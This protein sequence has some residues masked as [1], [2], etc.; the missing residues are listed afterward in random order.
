MHWT[1]LQTLKIADTN[2]RFVRKMTGQMPVLQSLKLGM[3]WTKGWCDIANQ[4][5]RF[6]AASP[7][8]SNLSLHG[9]AGL[10]NWTEILPRRGSALKSL[11][12]HE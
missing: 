2:L 11:R 8:L 5:S 9:Y 12:M 6:L 1:Q 3:R 4:T 10:M 7:P